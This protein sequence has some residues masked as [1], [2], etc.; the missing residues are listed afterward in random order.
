MRH[1][2][3]Q[4]RGQSL[5]VI[6]FAIIGLIGLTALA[7]D[8]GNIFSERRHAQTAADSAVLAAALA[9][10]HD[11]DWRT[12]AMGIARSNGYFDDRVNDTVTFNNPPVANDCNP[13]DTA[14]IYVGN[15]E[16]IQA[17]I[18]VN[19]QTYFA[20]VVGF[21]TLQVCV[22]AIARARPSHTAPM[23][24]GNAMV[25]LNPH[26]CQAVRI[27]GN[28]DAVLID[29]GLFVNSDSTCGQGAFNQGGSST[30]NAPGI[31]VVGSYSYDPGDVVPPPTHCNPVPYPP[32]FIL[33]T[34]SCA[35]D[36]SKSG[37]VLTP[38][39][40]PA[41]WLGG[42]ITLQA[43]VY[44][45]NGDVSINSHDHIGG[46]N[47]LLY[48][49]NGGLHINGGAELL[50]DAPDTGPYAGLLFYFPMDNHNPIILNGNAASRFTGSILAPASDIQIN[51]TGNADTYQTQVIGYTLDIRGTSDSVI[52]YNDNQN[53]DATVP[54]A[55]EMV[56]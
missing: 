1:H 32:D 50:L 23:V 42:N 22:E 2:P 27:G 54:P 26:D 41:S 3:Q 8:G 29:G 55:V 18:E 19:V 40:I 37:N 21:D 16:Y 20:S 38:G 48:F 56:K 14:S 47:V 11:Q 24:F 46:S 51:G 39:N 13:N 4:A 28:G 53:Y 9:K 30:L 33:P 15:D 35:S 10:V 5:I 6:V 45:I 34:V 36:G 17:I 7:V 25:G 43:G 52:R 12:A 49:A 31:C 44:C